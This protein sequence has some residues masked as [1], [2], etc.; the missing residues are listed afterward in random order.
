LSW[1]G[2]GIDD[3][4]PDLQQILATSEAGNAER[5]QDSGEDEEG[6][7]FHEVALSEG[8]DAG[9]GPKSFALASLSD[10]RPALNLAAGI[11]TDVRDAQREF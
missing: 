6:M 9:R 5:E 7:G 4:V 3:D 11:K 10:H 1:G 2:G 8:L